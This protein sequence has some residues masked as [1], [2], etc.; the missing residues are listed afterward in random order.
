MFQILILYVQVHH[1]LQWL[2]GIFNIKA[3]KY[4]S[5]NISQT[6]FKYHVILK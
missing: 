1:L 6:G 2:W 5:K 4:P 3:H